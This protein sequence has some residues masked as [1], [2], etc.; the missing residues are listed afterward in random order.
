MASLLLRLQEEA[1]L[2]A[3]EAQKGPISYQLSA[4]PADPARCRPAQQACTH[5]AVSS[6]SA[7]VVCPRALR[8]AAASVRS[9]HQVQAHVRP[10]CQ[11]HLDPHVLLLCSFAPPRERQHRLRPA[12]R[13]TGR[14]AP[15]Q[16]TT[17]ALQSFCIAKLAKHKQGCRS[18]DTSDG[19]TATEPDAPAPPE[20]PRA[21]ISKQHERLDGKV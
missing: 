8:A 11:L 14:H 20:K 21:A 3:P 7:T 13:S 15:H 18:L 12:H 2:P 17:Q 1:L 19:Q 6:L 5:A 10:V 16:P 9:A 4:T